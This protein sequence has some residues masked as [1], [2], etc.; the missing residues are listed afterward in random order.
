M[1]TDCP[2][3]L[4]EWLDS[5]QPTTGWAYLRDAPND[6]AVRCATV[7]WLLRDGEVKLVCQT[8]GDFGDNGDPQGMG[9]VQIPACA[10]VKVS[11][12]REVSERASSSA[13]RRS[14]SAGKRQE[15]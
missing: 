14:A 12:L 1:R 13:R 8:V 2:L 15:P 11:V 10:V 3:V 5:R 6:P 9:M 7:G 4:V